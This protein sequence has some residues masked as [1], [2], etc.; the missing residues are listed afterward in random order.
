MLSID[1]N[2]LLY[3]Q[4]SD[5][6]EHSRAVAF[7]IEC[8]SRS[9]VVLCELVLVE[10]YILLRNPAVVRYPLDAKEAAAICQTYRAHP[11]WRLVENGPV[12]EEVWK[13]ATKPSFAR[14]R[15]IDARLART[16]QYHGVKELATVNTRDF[17]GLGFSRVWNPLA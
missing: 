12:M 2:I 6:P 17:V 4:N 9:D 5:C 14:R 16:L 7:L 15:V 1:T 11:R 8:S 13:L 3:A 10:L